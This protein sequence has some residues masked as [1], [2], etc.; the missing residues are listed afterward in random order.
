L[1]SII[2]DALKRISDAFAELDRS[3]ILEL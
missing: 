1:R 2:L 3:Q